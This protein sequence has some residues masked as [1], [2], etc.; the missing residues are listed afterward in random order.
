VEGNNSDDD[1][2]MGTQRNRNESDQVKARQDKIEASAA[3]ATK[4][5]RHPPNFEEPKIKA[6]PGMYSPKQNNRK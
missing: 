2:E 4:N 5:P 1:E 3:E 6:T